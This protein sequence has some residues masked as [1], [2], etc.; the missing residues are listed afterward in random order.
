M[1]NLKKKGKKPYEEEY[2]A[3]DL[4]KKTGGAIPR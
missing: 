1:G 4:T 2:E 3:W